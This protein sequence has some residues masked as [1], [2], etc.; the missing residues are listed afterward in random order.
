[1]SD[2]L[3]RLKNRNDSIEFISLIVFS[4]CLVALSFFSVGFLYA[5]VL[6]SV[7]LIKLFAIFGAA[8]IALLFYVVKEFRKLTRI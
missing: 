8:N 2:I 3:K 5:Q 4:F 6:D 1:M 7:F